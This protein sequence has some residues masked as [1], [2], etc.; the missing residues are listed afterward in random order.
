MTADFT[1]DMLFI[2]VNRHETR[3]LLSVFEEETKKAAEAVPIGDRT[4]RKLGTVN[5]TTVC[6]AL[7]Q[8]AGGGLGGSQQTV[9]R[10]IRALHPSA[11]VLIGVAFGVNPAKQRIGDILLSRGLSRFP[12]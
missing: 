10:A 2:T 1:T 4:Y 9:D 7:S 3:A 5:D 12:C 8:M 11:I 6:H